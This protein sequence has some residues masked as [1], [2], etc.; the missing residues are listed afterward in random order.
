MRVDV[1]VGTN[2]HM[3]LCT[4][5]CRK[6]AELSYTEMGVCAALC[7]KSKRVH[8]LVGLR[9]MQLRT[10]CVREGWLWGGAGGRNTL[11]SGLSP[12]SY[13]CRGH[14]L[15]LHPTPCYSM[16]CVRKNLSLAPT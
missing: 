3:Y 15:L 8:S 11:L 9:H 4:Y 6:G 14:P 2:M 16:H 7:K 10:L 12:P 5:S 1:H 13:A